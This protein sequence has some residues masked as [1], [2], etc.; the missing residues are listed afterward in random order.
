M[1]GQIVSA[2]EESTQKTSRFN[3]E[4]NSEVT[5]RWGVNWIHLVRDRNQWRVEVNTWRTVVFQVRQ[6]ISRRG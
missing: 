1:Y 2:A 6:G 4:T 5:V 3:T